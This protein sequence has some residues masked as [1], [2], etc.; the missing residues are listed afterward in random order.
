MDWLYLAALLMLRPG[1]NLKSRI[2]KLERQAA[3]VSTRELLPTDGMLDISDYGYIHP[4]LVVPGLVTRPN[5]FA[6]YPT[7]P[8]EVPTFGLSGPS[9]GSKPPDALSFLTTSPLLGI[10]YL[11]P[12]DPFLLFTPHLTRKRR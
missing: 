4:G 9:V 12:S 1:K 8:A 3:L 2:E 10:F 11:S 6:S 5:G 7:S